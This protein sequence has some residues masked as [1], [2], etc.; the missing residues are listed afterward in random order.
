[1][2]VGDEDV[3]VGRDGDVGRAVERIGAVARHALLAERHHQLSVARELEHL[4]ADAVAR[5]AVGDPEKAV[6]V[7]ADAVRPHEHL[8]APR[9]QHLARRVELDDRRLGA[10]EREDP[11]GRV[12][13]HAGHFAELHARRQ[14]T[15]VRARAGTRRRRCRP[16][17]G[18]TSAPCP[19]ARAVG[20]PASHTS[21]PPTN[22]FSTPDGSTAGSVNVDRSTIVFG[23][24]STTSATAP[25]LDAAAVLRAAAA[26]PARSSSCGSPPAASATARRARTCRARAGTC[27]RRADGGSRCRRRSPPSPTAAGRTPAC[28]RPPST[29]RRRWRRRP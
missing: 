28:R 8:L 25:D 1:M 2:A 9:L 11:A 18:R 26:P 27:R 13:R 5:A 17:C 29:C 7:D 12:D 15:P 22:T 6:A 24:N 3:A 21:S 10:V 14:L 23:L 20:L 16:A 19:A 4:L